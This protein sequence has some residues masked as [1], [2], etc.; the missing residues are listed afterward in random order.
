MVKCTEQYLF[1]IF[2]GRDPQ[3]QMEF[4]YQQELLMM[5]L[6]QQQIQADQVR[7]IQ[8]AQIQYQNAQQRYLAVSI[9]LIEVQ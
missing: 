5:R 4:Q 6:Q 8:L 9:N 2:R 7:Q 3:Q 1:S